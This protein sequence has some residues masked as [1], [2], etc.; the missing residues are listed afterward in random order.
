MQLWQGKR[1]V[2]LTALI[3]DVFSFVNLVVAFS[4]PYWFISWP[5]VY[6]GF[7]NIGLWEVCFAGMLLK[8]DPRQQSYHGC[9]WILAPELYNIRGWMMPPWFIVVQILMTI[10]CCIEFVNVI[11]VILIWLRTRKSDKSGHGER[12]PLYR[13]VHT[14]WIIAIISS[15]IKV[16]SVIMFGLGAEYDQYWMPDP[17]INY[18]HISY[19]LAILSCFGTI[20]SSMAHQVYRNIVLKEY[21]QPAMETATTQPGPLRAP[22]PKQ[23]YKI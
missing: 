10:A 8:R 7:R 6:S 1:Y 14:T 19:G 17:E 12:R 15:S 4:T 21:R 22:Y 18:P 16:I 5:R 13:R 2:L 23:S 3:L 9:W 11:I 20:F